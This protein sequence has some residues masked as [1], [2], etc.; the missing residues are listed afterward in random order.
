MCN[1]AGLDSLERR[2][3][4]EIIELN[5]DTSFEDVVVERFLRWGD[6]FAIIRRNVGYNDVRFPLLVAIRL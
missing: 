1:N 6:T 3:D 5:N 4:G 2:K